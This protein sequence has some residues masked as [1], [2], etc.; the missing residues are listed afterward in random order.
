[1]A[2]NA[3]YGEQRW[4]NSRIHFPKGKLL[5][6]G[7]VANSLSSSAL[8]ILPFPPELAM[9]KGYLKPSSPTYF[10]LEIEKDYCGSRAR[11]LPL[12]LRVHLQAAV[13]LHKHRSDPNNI[14]DMCLFNYPS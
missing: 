1:M 13:Q 11:S 9:L 10:S 7:L 4:R 6:S 5:G 8:S 14:T 12:S 3:V 2:Q